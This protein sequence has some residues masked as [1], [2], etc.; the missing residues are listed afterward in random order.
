MKYSFQLVVTVLG[1][2]FS[3]SQA[4][5]NN[6]P[7]DYASSTSNI[8]LNQSSTDDLNGR[9]T[10][11][12]HVASQGNLVSLTDA[13]FSSSPT[14]TVR[15]GP[16]NATVSLSWDFG[17]QIDPGTRRLETLSIWLAAD[18]QRNGFNGSLATSLDGVNFTAVDNSSHIWFFDGAAA[19]GGVSPG[20]HHILYNFTGTNVSNFRFLQ[21]NTS[22][23]EFVSGTPFQPLFVEIDGV[24]SVPEP[25]TI[26]LLALG[27][28]VLGLASRRDKKTSA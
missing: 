19:A 14:D 6:S 10:A 28:G 9:L 17:T 13:S 18:S 22:G 26:A 8:A 23:A 3:A 15:V 12:T 20:F 11:S 25:S 2:S 4:N 1:I 5:A 7:S 16:D 27:A 21:L 24:V